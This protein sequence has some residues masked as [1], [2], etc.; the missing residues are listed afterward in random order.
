MVSQS[1]NRW[2]YFASSEAPDARLASDDLASDFEWCIDCCDWLRNESFQES[3]REGIGPQLIGE[4]S[5][6]SIGLEPPA[7]V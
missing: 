1:V 6:H 2:K 7:K 5:L 3:C 4:Q